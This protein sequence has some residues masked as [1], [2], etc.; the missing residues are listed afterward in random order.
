M[1]IRITDLQQ[2]VGSYLVKLAEE[3]SLKQFLEAL[4]QEDGAYILARTKLQPEV[5]WC[6]V[7]ILNSKKTERKSAVMSQDTSKL[8]L[9]SPSELRIISPSCLDNAST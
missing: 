6:A 4:T 5:F 1:K 8:R 9:S 7:Q 3:L 2:A